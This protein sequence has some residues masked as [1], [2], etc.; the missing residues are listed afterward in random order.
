[1]RP[2]KPLNCLL[3]AREAKTVHNLCATTL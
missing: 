3:P 1:L 2:S